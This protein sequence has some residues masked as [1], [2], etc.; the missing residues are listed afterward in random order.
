[1]SNQE[2]ARKIKAVDD[3]E[4]VR[5]GLIREFALMYW[6]VYVA[7][8]VVADGIP[9]GQPHYSLVDAYKDAYSFL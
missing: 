1:M 5:V 9:Q 6:Q 4:S 7:S 8:P 3:S 2:L